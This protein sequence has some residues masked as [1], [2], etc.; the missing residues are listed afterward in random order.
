MK[1]FATVYAAA[2]A[3]RGSPSYGLDGRTTGSCAAVTNQAC[4]GIEY[5]STSPSSCAPE[6][7][8]CDEVCCEFGDCCSDYDT[9]GVCST[10]LGTCA[11]QTYEPHTDAWDKITTASYAIRQDIKDFYAA[12]PGLGP[13]SKLSL[14]KAARYDDFFNKMYRL[15]VFF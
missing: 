9:T 3:T 7:C 4:C 8:W 14:K 2:L 13:S 6:G 5:P 10:L 1:L 11:V 12:L 15:K